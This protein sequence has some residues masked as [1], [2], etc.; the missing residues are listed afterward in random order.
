MGASMKPKVSLRAL[1]FSIDRLE[2]APAN[3]IWTGSPGIRRG[4]KKL[5]VAAAMNAAR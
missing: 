4:R 1:R 2:P 3:M 5:I